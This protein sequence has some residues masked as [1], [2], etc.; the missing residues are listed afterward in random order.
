MGTQR[1]WIKAV[2]GEEIP[3]DLPEPLKSTLRLERR[4]NPVPTVEVWLGQSPVLRV[5][6]EDML[7]GRIDY[8]DLR[9]L[10][11]AISGSS[12]G[13]TVGGGLFQGTRVT[14]ARAMMKIA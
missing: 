13:L 2:V 5:R 9:P 8:I 6:Q 7:V 4:T 12:D 10:G 1:H 3:A 14:N 11:L